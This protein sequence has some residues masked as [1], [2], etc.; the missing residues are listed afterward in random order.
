[1][2]THNFQQLRAGMSA[3]SKA[4]SA[5]EHRRLVEERAGDV[6]G[7]DDISGGKGHR[8]QMSSD[9]RLALIKQLALM[10]VEIHA[11]RLAV[12]KAGIDDHE[13]K[14]FRDTAKKDI[15]RAEEHFAENLPPLS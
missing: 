15:H 1:M 7:Q 12:K 14:T 6:P 11:L 8:T 2:A 9:F 4:A 5:T 3:E 10:R 13:L